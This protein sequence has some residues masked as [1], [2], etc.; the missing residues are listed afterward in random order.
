M[1]YAILDETKD[2]SV[3]VMHILNIALQ[4]ALDIILRLLL[5]HPNGLVDSETTFLCTLD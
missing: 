4:L 5:N 3:H 2:V 1:I